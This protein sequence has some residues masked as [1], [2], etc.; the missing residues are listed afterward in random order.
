MQI[1]GYLKNIGATYASCVVTQ[2]S[3]TA[4][5]LLWE[6]AGS[7][8]QTGRLPT[9]LFL[10]QWRYYSLNI[11]GC[12]QRTRKLFCGRVVYGTLLQP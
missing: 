10:P 7:E 5:E 1:H 12:S 9:D 11:R 6:S 3:S 4:V 8:Q 2:V